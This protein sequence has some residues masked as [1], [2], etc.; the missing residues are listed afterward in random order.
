VNA[1]PDPTF[2]DVAKLIAAPGPP[3]EWLEEKL[4]KLAAILVFGL[5]HQD[6]QPGRSEMRKRLKTYGEAAKTLL[7][8]FE[9][10]LPSL[11]HIEAAGGSIEE[12]GG[13]AHDL[14]QV[15]GGAKR[16]RADISTHGG[17]AKAWALQE[18]LSP[19]DYCALVIREAWQIIHEEYPGPRRPEAIEAADAYWLASG[20][21]RM[22]KSGREARGWRAHFE[23]AARDEHAH[24]RE[25]IRRL[26]IAS[27]PC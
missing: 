2:A 26:I 25:K 11:L 16:A 27:V 8:L 9:E 21:P 23:A 3:P 22:G 24:E 4:R 20:G 17:P 14:K 15:I 12:I 10:D 18:V 13:M 6:Q 1:I 5:R 7:R 19:K